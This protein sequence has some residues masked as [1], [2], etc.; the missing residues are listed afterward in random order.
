[1]AV[2]DAIVTAG[3]TKDFGGGRGI[4]DLDL[5]VGQG[6]VVGFLG[7]NGAGKTTTLRLLMG[8][9]RPDRG[10]ASLLGEP[11]A[12][13][14]S[15]LHRRIGYIP[16]E[17][18]LPGAER[19]QAYLDRCARLQRLDDRTRQGELVNLL[20]LPADLRIRELSKG[21]R[22][23]VALV[24]ALQ[25]QPELLILDE[26]TDGL[27]PVLRQRVGQL[28]RQ[29]AKAGGTV[30]L[31]SHVVHEVEAVCDDVAVVVD[32]RLRA[33]ANIAA[34]LA[35]LP[36]RLSVAVPTEREGVYQVLRR[37]GA[38]MQDL[39]TRLRVQ[40]AGDALRFLAELHAA[41]ARDVAFEHRDLEETFMRLYKGEPA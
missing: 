7:P 24:Q 32:G 40:V 29:H 1:M 38:R 17:L 10:T 5:K 20:G 16:G 37:H 3:L 22:Q 27:D 21:N 23:K 41:G 35:R 4:L 12:A 15:R 39:G 30:F 19:V 36:L 33:Q 28:L 9:L 13:D 8:F 6:R 14:R 34:L 31:S 25:H 11:L 2:G 18:Q 26:P